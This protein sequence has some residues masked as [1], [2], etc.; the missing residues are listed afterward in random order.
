V[1]IVSGGR[2]ASVDA[3]AELRDA[4]AAIRPPGP[5][6]PVR[7]ATAPAPAR[8]AGAPGAAA[9]PPRPDGAAA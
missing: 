4:I 2:H 9:H 3:A 1:M 6:R 5:H 8:P 7:T